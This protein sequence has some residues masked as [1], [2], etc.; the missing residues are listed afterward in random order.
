MEAM[1]FRDKQ[2]PATSPY[3]TSAQLSRLGLFGRGKLRIRRGAR[4]VSDKATG[5][6]DA[7]TILLAMTDQ[8]RAALVR[9]AKALKELLENKVTP[10]P[11]ERSVIQACREIIDLFEP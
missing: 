4:A 6:E 11:R 7:K 3:T 9:L 2:R 5:G 10:L 1:G 8:Q